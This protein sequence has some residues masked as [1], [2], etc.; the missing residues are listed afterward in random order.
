MSALTDGFANYSREGKSTLQ[1]ATPCP[2]LRD[3]L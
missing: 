3:Y 2:E 1:P